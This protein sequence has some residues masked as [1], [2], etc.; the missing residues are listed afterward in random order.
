[1]TQQ[2]FQVGEIAV[3]ACTFRHTQ[4]IGSECT[5]TGPLEDRS[6]DWLGLPMKLNGYQIKTPDNRHFIAPP[7]CLRK[8]YVP[9]K[10]WSELRDEL[11]KR[12]VTE[13]CEA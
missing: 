11:N 13:E 1:M 10:P 12:P 2:Y 3:I 6:Y 7:V 9:G 5:I 4:Y 8:R